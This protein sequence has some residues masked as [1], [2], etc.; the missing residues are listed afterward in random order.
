[1]WRDEDGGVVVI[2]LGGDLKSV[3]LWLGKKC[4][5]NGRAR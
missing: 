5:V 2:F 3:G 1:V 4:R